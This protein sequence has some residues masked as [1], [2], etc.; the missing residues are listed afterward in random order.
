MNIK[1]IVGLV[2]SLISIANAD[3]YSGHY[4]YDLQP[5]KPEG[6]YGHVIIEHILGDIYTF[7]MDLGRGAPSYN[8]GILEGN[9]TIKNGEGIYYKKSESSH[10]DA[11]EWKMAF[12]GEK[13]II[14]TLN[15]HIDCDFGYAVFVDG[16]YY[17]Q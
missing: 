13:L 16:N 11:C 4:S 10:R 17:K 6:R 1:L 15:N 3:S 8:T 9:I 5:N 14:K 2:F 12:S 7:K